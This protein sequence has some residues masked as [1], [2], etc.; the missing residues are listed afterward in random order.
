[1]VLLSC[2]IHCESS[3]STIDLSRLSARWPPTLRPSQLTWAKSAESWLLPSTFTI[4]ICIITQPISLP[5]S[6][7]EG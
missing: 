6:R 1:M 5:P 3:P 7:V 4:A 2:Q